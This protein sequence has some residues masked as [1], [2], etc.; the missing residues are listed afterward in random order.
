M[1]R[2]TFLACLLWVTTDGYFITVP[3]VN[4]SSK[5]NVP[6]KPDWVRKRTRPFGGE[7]RFAVSGEEPE[8]S[9]PKVKEMAS[10][11]AMQLLERALSDFVREDGKSSMSLED[12]QKLE[13][14]M[15]TRPTKSP[16]VEEKPET[17]VEPV[18]D[19][20]DDEDSNESKVEVAPEEISPAKL[21]KNKIEGKEEPS[22]EPSKMEVEETEE[23][24]PQIQISNED[25]VEVPPE[26]QDSTVQEEQ[27]Q[28]VLVEVEEEEEEKS[29][30][31]DMRSG[32]EVGEEVE[33]LSD[34]TDPPAGDESLS[35]VAQFPEVISKDFGRPLEILQ[36]AVPALRESSI[37]KTTL[38]SKEDG[39]PSEKSKKDLK[40]E[41]VE[42]MVGDDSDPTLESSSENQ[43]DMEKVSDGA[44]SQNEGKFQRPLDEIVARVNPPLTESPSDG[45][46][47]TVE[48]VKLSPAE[49]LEKV[50]EQSKSTQ[51]E[52]ELAN[53]CKE[54]SSEDRPFSTLND[55]G[56]AS[57]TSDD[58]QEADVVTTVDLAAATD[59]RKE[60][61]DSMVSLPPEVPKAVSEESLASKSAFA[62]EKSS[63]V[64]STS[65]EQI[66]N[67]SSKSEF[68]SQKFRGLSSLR[69]KP[70]LTKFLSGIGSGF[71]EQEILKARQQPKSGKGEELDAARYE[72]M[73]LEDRAFAILYDLGMIE[74]HENPNSIDY[75]HSNDDEYCI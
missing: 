52:K 68:F 42:Q 43:S 71:R 12:F 37:P 59:D 54:T 21:E 73:S 56:M 49:S 75:D 36:S 4:T 48:S 31:M 17:P 5:W 63:N 65:T 9:N 67:A 2:S 34:T 33:D 46:S 23:E 51:E 20:L 18:F 47:I 30:E 55:L 11:L 15:Q 25:E 6:N 8:S 57:N 41:T 69:K 40:A 45:D 22:S 35:A 53:K 27:Q 7:S 58:D 19:L 39:V 74:I 24:K 60:A 64:K 14:A 66:E 10:F 28:E 61:K 32:S 16:E 62:S 50:L 29:E 72:L 13:D 1:R 26:T 70:S 44:E 38:P 3:V